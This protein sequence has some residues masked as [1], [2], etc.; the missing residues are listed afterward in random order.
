MLPVLI[1][2]AIALLGGIILVVAS[3][4]MAVPVD[5]KTQLI[6][7]ALPGA[8][9]GG[10]GYAGCSAYAEAITSGSAPGNLC[11]PGG[12]KVAA[13]ISK[14]TGLAVV[15]GVPKT[16]V[17]ACLGTL[18]KTKAKMDYQ[19][20]QTCEAASAFFGGTGSC[21]YGC[22]GYGDCVQKCVYD[23]IQIENGVAKIDQ[24]KCTG[25]T[26]CVKSCPKSIIKMIR[27]DQTHFVTC[28]SKDSTAITAKACKAGCI[29]CSRCVKVCP[30]SAITVE[31]GLAKIDYTLCTSCGQ[32]TTV[33][34]TGVILQRD[35]CSI[36]KAI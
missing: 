34:P 6:S 20:I 28:S 26:T 19:G 23:A 25:C 21:A 1:L 24:T 27:I 4:F 13:E 9:C 15:T 31:N 33:C 29:A 7:E 35:T 36:E 8:N 30:S 5:E 10:C 16:A 17:V 14:I 32:C 3:I 18:D 22:L 12:S 11:A 2:T